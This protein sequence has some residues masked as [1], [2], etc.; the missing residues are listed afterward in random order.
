MIL[1][2]F[3]DV[4]HKSKFSQKKSGTGP[5]FFPSL[6]DSAVSVPYSSSAGRPLRKQGICRPEDLASPGWLQPASLREALLFEKWS[7]TLRVCLMADFCA[8]DSASPGWL[9]PTSL[10][11]ALLFEKWSR[12]LRV[13]LMADFCAHTPLGMT[14]AIFFPSPLYF[15]GTARK[16]SAYRFPFQVTPSASSLL[17]K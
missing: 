6:L 7:R 14:A 16:T 9:Q 12:T 13:C 3:P 17:S 10:R 15:F 1:S 8:R 5:L 11:E 4:K 2:A